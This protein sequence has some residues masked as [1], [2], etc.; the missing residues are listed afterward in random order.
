MG[1]LR[2]GEMPAM[3]HRMAGAA[4]VFRRDPGMRK[5]MPPVRKT[6]SALNEPDQGRR[7]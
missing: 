3:K 7:D 1:G 4:M 5:R 6:G 2:V